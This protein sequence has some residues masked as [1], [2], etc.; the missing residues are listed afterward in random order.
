[1]V[2]ANAFA[3]GAEILDST[4]ATTIKFEGELKS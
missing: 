2:H 3:D 1:M 4:D